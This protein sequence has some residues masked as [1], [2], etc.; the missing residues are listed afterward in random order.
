[1]GDDFNNR[2]VFADR[3]DPVRVR[4]DLIALMKRSLL[5]QGY[6]VAATEKDADRSIV[7]GPAERWIWLGDSAGSTETLDG[8]AFRS[9]SLAL[10]AFKPVVDVSM[11]DSVAVWFT[12]YLGGG[13]V[14]SFGTPLLSFSDD[15]EANYWAGRP[16]FWRELLIASEQVDVLRFVWVQ[17]SNGR[18]ILDA[19]A[20]LFGWNPHLVW[21]GYTL[22]TDQEP[23]R[24][25]ELRAAETPISAFEEFHFRKRLVAEIGSQPTCS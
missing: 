21:F 1:M 5:E 22:D 10:S 7:V 23:M 20:D 16:E 11:S 3:G 14:D 9:L 4:A 25:D 24:W 2:Q 8:K 12:L 13:I 19:T 18:D 6:D 17:Q 15:K